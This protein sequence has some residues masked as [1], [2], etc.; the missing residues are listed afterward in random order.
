MD[1]V[2]KSLQG[3]N[4]L[5]G[6]SHLAEPHPV[7]AV[8][9]VPGDLLEMRLQ[10]R[11]SLAHA[12]PGVMHKWT[13]FWCIFLSRYSVRGLWL[14]LVHQITLWYKLHTFVDWFSPNVIACYL[15][16]LSLH[17]APYLDAVTLSTWRW[18]RMDGRYL[19]MTRH[20]TRHRLQR[21]LALTQS[22]DWL[23]KSF[24]QACHDLL[25]LENHQSSMELNDKMD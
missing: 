18:P 10:C 12:G 2:W 22:G 3:C 14:L 16:R 9:F 24:Y 19:N 7:Q 21:N 25:Y 23:G 5:T 1:W 17:P 20:N 4:Q 15:S 13:R 6:T 11:F 8:H